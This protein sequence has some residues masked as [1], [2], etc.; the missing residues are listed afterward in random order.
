VESDFSVFHR[1]DDP[2]VLPAHLFVARLEQLI[3][4]PGAVRARALA[5]L[6]RARVQ[7]GLPGQGGSVQSDAQTTWVDDVTT[8]PAFAGAVARQQ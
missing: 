8:H 6:E 4:Y 5:E 2:Y 7:D 1:V 3:H